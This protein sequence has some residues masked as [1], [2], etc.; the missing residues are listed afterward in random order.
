M[1]SKMSKKKRKSEI[2]K[3]KC[4][5]IVSGISRRRL[6][7]NVVG[8]VSDAMLLHSAG[9]VEA[10]AANVAEKRRL[11]SVGADVNLQVPVQSERLVA[12]RT[13]VRA[14]ASVRLEVSL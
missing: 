5:S 3:N 4:G 1:P 12:V 8:I 9:M 11:A 6:L 13:R 14:L 10:L 7:L 2:A